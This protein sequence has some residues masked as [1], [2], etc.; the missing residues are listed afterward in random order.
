[1]IVQM[2]RDGTRKVNGKTVKGEPVGIVVAIGKGCI[3]WSL[4]NPTSFIG[5]D[6]TVWKGDVWNKKRGMELAQ[7]RA[8]EM[9]TVLDKVSGPEAEIIKNKI[10]V[11]F[12]NRVPHTV[13]RVWKT[14][15]DRSIKAKMFDTGSCTE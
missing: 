7:K 3:G 1:M 15:Y 2:V 8:V 10:V 5:L 13:K 12:F 11:N 4:R 6:G 9:K 14:V